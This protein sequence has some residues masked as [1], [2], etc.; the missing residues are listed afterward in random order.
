MWRTR[1]PANEKGAE[2]VTREV[3][4]YYALC[5]RWDEG[6]PEE[7]EEEVAPVLAGHDEFGRIVSISVYTDPDGPAAREDLSRVYEGGEVAIREASREELLDTMRR[8]LI[9]SVFLDGKKIAGSVFTGMLKTD[10]GL[11]IKHPRMVRLDELLPPED[12]SEP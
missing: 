8:R 6:E 11:P 9:R 2:D 3:R 7:K 5:V 12:L 1:R 10:L 4:E